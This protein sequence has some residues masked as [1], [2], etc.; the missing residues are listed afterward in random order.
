MSQLVTRSK[1]DEVNLSQK[2]HCDEMTV[3]LVTATFMHVSLKVIGTDTDQSG[4]VPI[5][6]INFP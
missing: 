2:I 1:I 3:W 6:S 4:T 5:T